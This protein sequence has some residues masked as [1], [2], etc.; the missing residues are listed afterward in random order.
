MSLI[1]EEVRGVWRSW[2]T[3][4][5]GEIPWM[6]LDVK[7]LVTIAVGCLIDP[8]PL[9]QRLEFKREDGSRATPA[10]IG[11]EWTR[12][13][14]TTSLAKRGAKAALP[15]CLLRLSAEEIGR[16]VNARLS[17]NAILLRAK[18]F[19]DFE[20]WPSD[21]QHAMLSMAWAMGADFPKSWP[22]FSRFAK[23]RDWAQCAANCK[24]R[25]QGNPG[26]IARNVANAAMF[27]AASREEP[28]P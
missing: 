15:L 21:A 2:N 16:L 25:E 9:A 13:K 5:E 23:A 17:A 8:L 14:H 28:M 26:L 18:H 6:Y 10:E 24:M 11:F 27:R 12:I 7:G 4:F 1:R 3:Q 19:P 22:T 20:S